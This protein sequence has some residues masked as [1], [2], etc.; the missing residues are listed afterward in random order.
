[1]S[2]V[3]IKEAVSILQYVLR[4]FNEWWPRHVVHGEVWELALHRKGMTQAELEAAYTQF[5]RQTGRKAIDLATAAFADLDLREGQDPNR[6]LRLPGWFALDEPPTVHAQH[7]N[8]ART[9]LEAVIANVAE[10]MRG[11]GRTVEGKSI[12]SKLLRTACPGISVRQVFRKVQAFD[13]K[14]R[15]ISFIWAGETAA[16]SLTTVREEI[17]RL[18]A[19]ELAL[20]P[21]ARA[22]STMTKFAEAKNHLQ[23]LAPDVQLV[24]VSKAPEHPRAM[25][26][27]R[28]K[29][30][31]DAMLH[32]SLP[33][34]VYQPSGEGPPRIHELRPFESSK[35]ATATAARLQGAKILEHESRTLYL[36]EPTRKSESRLFVAERLGS[37]RIRSTYGQTPPK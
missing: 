20:S 29:S 25:L 8:A 4:E 36:H 14:P 22:Q 2:H 15:T 26:Y 3:A 27:Y 10:D 35:T 19:L 7:V 34:F 1:M 31:Y 21:E 28:E 17:Q 23:T 30:K 24:A 37:M 13:A 11:E 16:H 6:T 32:A 12:R 5:H 33:L 18:D 9:N